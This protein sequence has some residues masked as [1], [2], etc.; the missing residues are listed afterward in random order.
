MSARIT[1][2]T[3]A[4]RQH[5]GLAWRAGIALVITLAAAFAAATPALA[6][7]RAPAEYEVIGTTAADGSGASTSWT[8]PAGAPY[9]FVPFVSAGDAGSVAAVEAGA[10][11]GAVLFQRPF[12]GTHDVGCAPDLGSD[13][14]PDLKWRGATARFS[15]PVDALDKPGA[16][17]SAGGAGERFS[18]L[19]V[20]RKDLG[21]P[22]GALLMNRRLV[23]G[24]NCPRAIHNTF[25]D[26]LFVPIAAPP[27]AARCYN[28][29]GTYPREGGKDFKVDFTSADRLVLLQPADL[30][31]RYRGIRHRFRIT[32]FDGEG[33]RGGAGEFRSTGQEAGDIRLELV[34]LR[35]RARSIKI[36][37]EGGPLAP[38]YVAS[39]AP[40]VAGT[41]PPPQPKTAAIATNPSPAPDKSVPAKPVPAQPGTAQST[42]A[43]PAPTQPIPAQ[44]APTQPAIAEVP[45]AAKLAAPPPVPA[46]A[47][48]PVP[49]DDVVS[50]SAPEPVE[51]PVAAP[52]PAP[53]PLQAALPA[54]RLQLPAVKPS[55]PMP[56]PT[57][58]IFEY[59][60]FEIYRLNY[61]LR[62]GADC[63]EPAA[64]A[65][66][67]RQ[68]FAKASNWRV[69][70]NIG[71]LFPTIVLTDKRICAQFPCDGFEAITC[72]K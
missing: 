20:Y 29:S 51:K 45:A 15:P 64:T 21:P 7:T 44:P 27:E 25:F 39:A 1:A 69:D 33:C 49:T 14:R 36:V 24:Q 19:V 66:C 59:P 52:R 16:G 35:D 3:G 22:P 62:W 56:S 38:Y 32:V 65:W 28:L 47:P 57:S 53:L 30:D 2:G 8:L 58:K 23:L 71:A 42:T 12:F 48:T 40:P 18:S 43:Q 50:A 10:G 60:V 63:G 13:T 72:S 54:P 55:Q 41:A 67:R 61:C 17:E 46:P 34:G 26:R 37:Y 31:D 5:W 11:V 6:G 68:G 70:K 4:A 9:L